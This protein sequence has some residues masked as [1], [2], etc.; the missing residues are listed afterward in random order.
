MNNHIRS[1]ENGDFEVI[2]LD[3]PSF[4]EAQKLRDE[5]LSKMKWNG[6]APSVNMQ[7]KVSMKTLQQQEPEAILSLGEAHDLQREII[8]RLQ[9]EID[10][11]TTLLESANE[12]IRQLES[13]IYGGSTK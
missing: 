6:V 1:L 13:Q 4:L 10:S 12:R 3:D 8:Y 2:P 11:L 7:W 5:S 9:N